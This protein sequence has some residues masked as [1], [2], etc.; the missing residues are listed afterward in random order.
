MSIIEL[1]VIHCADTPD[2]EPYLVDDIRKWH[3]DPPPAGNG[4]S[5]PGYHNVIE[6]SGYVATLLPHDLDAYL[7]SDEQANGA[8][9]YNDRAIHVCLIGT[10]RFTAPQWFSLAQFTADAER[11]Y[12]RV[13]IVGHRDLNPKKYCP[14]FDVAEWLAG[15][16]VAL[17]A[18]LLSRPEIF[19][20]DHR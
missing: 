8:I 12:P 20:N 18:H 14:G 13:N 5:K 15:G 4:W 1:L 17:P 16:R 19:K 7:T 9:A 11:M 3:T 6:I 10:D 2:G